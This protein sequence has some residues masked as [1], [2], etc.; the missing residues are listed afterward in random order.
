MGRTFYVTTPIYYVNDKP[1]IGTA[2]TTVAADALARYQRLKG[3]KVFF[4]TG[5][6]EHGQHVARAAEANGK[7]PQEWADIMVEYFTKLWKRLNIS[8]DDFIRTTSGRHTKVAQ[9]FIK[10]LYE[11]GDIYLDTYEGWYCVP[12]ETFW[13]PSQ[14]VDGRCPQCGREVEILKEENYF[15]RL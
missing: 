10:R 9:D 14:L 15:F 6:D 7:S 1:H 2:Y 5:T 13:L 11:N 12:D 8:N 3:Q 4:L